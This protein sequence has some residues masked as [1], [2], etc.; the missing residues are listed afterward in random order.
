MSSFSI[1]LNKYV[2][3]EAGVLTL[4]Y[5]NKIDPIGDEQVI[6]V[7]IYLYVLWNTSIIVNLFK[8]LL[9]KL[10]K[11][12]EPNQA[13]SHEEEIDIKMGNNRSLG[14]PFNFDSFL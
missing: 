11:D 5:M 13:D 12:L 6:F 3:L 14:E 7:L 9:L 2:F 4:E 10:A 1:K 8:R